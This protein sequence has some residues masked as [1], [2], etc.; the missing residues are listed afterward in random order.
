MHIEDNLLLEIVGILRPRLLLLQSLLLG[1]VILVVCVA[2]YI[3][4]V[5]F[6]LP[7]LSCAC[8]VCHRI[9]PMLF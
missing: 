9:L 4:N 1:G 8:L 5:V 3:L 7:T 2:L 6:Q